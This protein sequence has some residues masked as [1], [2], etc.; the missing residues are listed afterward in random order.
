MKALDKL[1]ITD[2]GLEAY[3]IRARSLEKL[4]TLYPGKLFVFRLTFPDGDHYYPAAVS[5]EYGDDDQTFTC[6]VALAKGDIKVF[7]TQRFGVVLKPFSQ[8]PTAVRGL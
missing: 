7:D 4:D 5:S 2:H 3:T 1:D 8:K 6:V